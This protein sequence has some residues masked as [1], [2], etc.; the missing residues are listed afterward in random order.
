MLPRRMIPRGPWPGVALVLLLASALALPAS[1]AE[2]TLRTDVPAGKL[3]SLRLRN[4]AE[5]TVVGVAVQA[6]GELA[7]AFV[8]GKALRKSPRGVPP[9]F[10]GRLDRR[11]AFSVTIPSP[12]H[13]YVVLDNRK[14]EDSRAVRVRV[15]AVRKAPRDL[16]KEKSRTF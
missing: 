10:T 2:V 13:Y 8:G 12:G 15:R 1:G 7:V 6:D 5:G 11:L 16:T 9:L 4:L 14:G 3:K